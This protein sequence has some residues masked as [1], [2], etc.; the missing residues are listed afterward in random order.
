MFTNFLGDTFDIIYIHEPSEKGFCGQKSQEIYTFIQQIREIE[1]YT[2]SRSGSTRSFHEGADVTSVFFPVLRQDVIN[3]IEAMDKIPVKL[4]MERYNDPIMVDLYSYLI[5]YYYQVLYKKT[6]SHPNNGALQI[7]TRNMTN[8][9]T[10]TSLQIN[11]MKPTHGRQVSLAQMISLPSN[12]VNDLNKSSYSSN[13]LNKSNVIDLNKKLEVA[14]PS[15]GRRNLHKSFELTHGL[16]NALSQ[17][18]QSSPKQVDLLLKK[19]SVTFDLN[20]EA[21]LK[22]DRSHRS[23]AASENELYSFEESSISRKSSTVSFAE[24]EKSTDIVKRVLQKLESDD[25]VFKPNK[26]KSTA[27]PK[28][29]INIKNAKPITIN[30]SDEFAFEENEKVT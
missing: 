12:D 30:E 10:N 1:K 8:H 24:T 16:F 15:P 22:S 19:K 6:P 2:K 23:D 11:Q 29:S 27:K 13:T 4:A 20:N 17:S 18:N 26:R 3:K 21:G 5:K 9:Q 25:F 7:N 28:F 14:D